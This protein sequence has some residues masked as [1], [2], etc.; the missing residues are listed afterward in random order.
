MRF[1]SNGH[2]HQSKLEEKRP[3]GLPLG[4][5]GSWKDAWQAKRPAHLDV[6]S[7]GKAEEDFYDGW[8]TEAERTPRGDP[9]SKAPAGNALTGKRGA[10]ASERD[11][12]PDPLM[13]WRRVLQGE[14]LEMG[15]A[16][17]KRWQNI[18]RW[19]LAGYK[20]AR[21]KAARS[22]PRCAQARHGQ[23]CESFSGACSH[24]C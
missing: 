8:H 15:Q 6:F 18:K 3:A 21:P 7:R 14:G 16:K 13:A 19:F 10:K 12:Y 23:D 17:G 5:F 9:G 24:C 2:N 11:A 20:A 22:N 1:H 4:K